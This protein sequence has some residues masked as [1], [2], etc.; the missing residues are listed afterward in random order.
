MLCNLELLAGSLGA[1]K[2]SL[3]I[4][5]VPVIAIITSVVVLGEPF[6]LTVAAG[7]VL[8][9]AGLLISEKK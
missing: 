8:T 4:Y 9:L 1:L 2:A 5:L 6:T 3:Y 7:V